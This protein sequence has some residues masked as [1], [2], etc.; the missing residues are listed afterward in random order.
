VFDPKRRPWVDLAQGD[1]AA[2]AAAVERCPTG[3]LSYTRTDG[4]ADERSRTWSRSA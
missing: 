1:A 4:V 3:A 2:I